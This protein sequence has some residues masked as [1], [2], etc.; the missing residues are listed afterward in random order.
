[1][2]ADV[3][4]PVIHDWAYQWAS[5]F[6]RLFSMNRDPT[7]AVHPSVLNGIQPKNL[8]LPFQ[9]FY[10]KLFTPGNLNKPFFPVVHNPEKAGKPLLF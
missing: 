5:L 9:T 8:S 6:L 2:V 3:K 10:E 4:W 1:M 7:P